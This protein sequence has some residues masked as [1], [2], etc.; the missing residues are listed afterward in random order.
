MATEPALIAEQV[1]CGYEGPPVLRGVDLAVA[2]GEVLGLIGP[3]GSGKSTLLRAFT[4]VLRLTGGRV[5]LAGRPL[6]SYHRSEIA[7]QI[8]VV[9]QMSGSLFA[10]TVE[11]YVLMG[12]TPHLGRLQSQRPSDLQAAREALELADLTALA[13][14]PI[15]ELSGGELQRAALA[16]AL[17]QQTNILLL[18]EPTAFLDLSH[19]H[20]IFELLTRLNREQSKTVVC[21]SH[22]L[23]LAAQYCGRVAVLADGQV[24]TEGPPQAVITEQMIAQV[25]HARVEVD[26]GPAAAP[27]VTLLPGPGEQK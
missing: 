19:Q 24:Y 17:A 9:P 21:V 18:D 6:S 20:A 16:R 23:N 3:N 1:V 25:Y 27:R 11:D 10:F 12:R 4:G 5:L 8:A 13:H 14:R 2:R 7:R 22:D 15:T 26:T